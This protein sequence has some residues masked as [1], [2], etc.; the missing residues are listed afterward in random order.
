MTMSTCEKCWSDSAWHRLIGDGDSYQE[1]VAK[2]NVTTEHKCTPEEQAGESAQD[3]PKCGRRCL[4]QWTGECMNT[5]CGQPV[6]KG[7]R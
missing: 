3:C 5:A 6:K 7:E 2:R 4:H 1:L